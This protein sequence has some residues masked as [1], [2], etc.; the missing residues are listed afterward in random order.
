MGASS[1]PDYPA[2]GRIY[3]VIVLSDG[4]QTKSRLRVKMK[5]S[6]LIIM[7]SK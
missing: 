6:W 2:F 4:G 5:N 7:T 1:L 3:P